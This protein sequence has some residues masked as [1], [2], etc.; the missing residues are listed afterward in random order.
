MDNSIAGTVSLTLG[1]KKYTL[2]YTWDAI[3]QITERFGDNA[4]LFDLKILPDVVA[5]G[6]QRH[7]PEEANVE[8]VKTM[9]PP[10]VETINIVT[11]GI[12]IAY[13]GN[14]EPPVDGTENPPQTKS[15]KAR[16]TASSAPSSSAVEQES[17]LES[18]G[19]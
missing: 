15:R 9:S 10:I 2:Q 8:F 7:H 17:V 16:S 18:S 1:G 14:K 5:I 12:N 4:N 19:V 6:L 3:A 13:F 11:K